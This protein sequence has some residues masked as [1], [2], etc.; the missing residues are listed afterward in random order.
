M[1]SKVV[2]LLYIANKLTSVFVQLITMAVPATFAAL[3]ASVVMTTKA[4]PI[5]PSAGALDNREY[6][7]TGLKVSICL[8]TS[9]YIQ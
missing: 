8:F 4:P 3:L 9:K 7:G 1:K 6:F 5:P 2:F